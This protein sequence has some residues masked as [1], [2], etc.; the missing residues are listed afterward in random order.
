M[1]ESK[2][3]DR[4]CGRNLDS[5]AICAPYMLIWSVFHETSTLETFLFAMF[6]MFKL[7]QKRNLISL[8]K[9]H[10]LMHVLSKRKLQESRLHTD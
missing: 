9:C 2:Q 8:I 5:A 3:E 10:Y 4:N 6:H 7:L 1:C